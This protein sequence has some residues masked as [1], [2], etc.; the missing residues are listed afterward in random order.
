M[1]NQTPTLEM[2]PPNAVQFPNSREDRGRKK[3]KN[4]M[5]RMA[6]TQPPS[7]NGVGYIVLACE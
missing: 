2:F 5:W 6:D 4:F 7:E 1:H 3:T